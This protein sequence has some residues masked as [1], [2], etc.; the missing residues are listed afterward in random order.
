MLTRAFAMVG[1]LV[2][3]SEAS[4]WRLSSVTANARSAWSRRISIR[5]VAHADGWGDRQPLEW[6]RTETSRADHSVSRLLQGAG[7]VW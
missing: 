3:A 4:T 2:L 1:A 6:E 7:T 5:C